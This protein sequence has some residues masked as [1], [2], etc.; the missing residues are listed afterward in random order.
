MADSKYTPDSQTV[1]EPEVVLIDDDLALML[2]GIVRTKMLGITRDEVAKYII[3]AY[4]WQNDHALHNIGACPSAVK[5]KHG[6]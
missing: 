5:C 3:R 1:R 6:D 4:L 2:D